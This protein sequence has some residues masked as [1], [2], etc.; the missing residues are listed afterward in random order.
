MSFEDLFVVS[1]F[2][3]NSVTSLAPG[4][5]TNVL[6]HLYLHTGKPLTGSGK[7]KLS[8][9]HWFIPQGLDHTTTQSAWS[10]LTLLTFCLDRLAATSFPEAE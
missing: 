10:S 1:I 7:P 6:I 8:R 5:L 4:G 9:V 2:D 3:I